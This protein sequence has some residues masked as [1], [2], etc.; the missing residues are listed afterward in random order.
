M[1]CFMCKGHVKPGAVN[2][3]VD[4]E[5]SIIIVKNV[6]ANVCKQC[7]E[8]FFDHDIVKKLEAIVEQAKQSKAEITVINYYDNVA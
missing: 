3:I 6:P 2:H 1:N 4:L 8:A 5:D 7:G